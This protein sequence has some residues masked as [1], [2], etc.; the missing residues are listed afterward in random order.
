MKRIIILFL[1]TVIVLSLVTL[2]VSATEDTAED[3]FDIETIDKVDGSTIIHYTDGSTLTIS[4]VRLNDQATALVSTAKSISADRVVTYEDADGV[5]QWNY[6]LYGTFSYVSG[7]SSTC[8]NASYTHE[9][10]DSGWD[11]SEGSA[12][13]SGN[14]ALGHGIYK[15]KFLFV[16]IKTYTIDISL[17]CDVY[18]NVT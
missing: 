7:V 16:T 13:R 15:L 2:P 12:S 1:S 10:F 5:L 3:V 18:G 17:T 11:F 9:I 4:S 6:T 14:K 8:T